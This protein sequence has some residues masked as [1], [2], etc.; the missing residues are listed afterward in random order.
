MG[1][2]KS[3]HALAGKEGAEVG[4]IVL[5]GFGSHGVEGLADAEAI[6]A[7]AL[8]LIDLFPVDGSHAGFK[9]LDINSGPE[10]GALVAGD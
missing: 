1:V 9:V 4:L 10:P 2:V 5:K 3:S 8:E 6:K 7:S